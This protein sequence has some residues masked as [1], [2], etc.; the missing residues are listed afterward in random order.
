[1]ILLNVY[2]LIAFM[3]SNLIKLLYLLVFT[4]FL[5]NNSLAG[6]KEAKIAFSEG[7][8][9]KALGEFKKLADLGD[10]EAMYNLAVMYR[11]GAGNDSGEPEEEKAF[12]WYL[13]AAENGHGE[14]QFIVG[15]MYAGGTETL[16]KDFNKSNRWFK[17]SAGHHNK[18]AEFS[19]GIV[20]EEGLGVKKNIYQSYNWY[21]RAADH[22]HKVARFIMAVKYKNEGNIEKAFQF[23]TLSA[24]QGYIKSQN[25]LA[26]MYARGEGTKQNTLEAIRWYSAAAVEGDLIAIINLAA[27]YGNGIGI[28]INNVE[29]YKWFLIAGKRGD[30]NIESS[31][32]ILK[33][34]MTK[35]EIK[36]AYD[37]AELW[38]VKHFKYGQG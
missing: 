25:D 34:L 38:I 37:D 36:Q 13:K 12:N 35:K 1:M 33:P 21:K 14:S 26:G 17:K 30:K 5:I 16:K 23:Y 28:E 11:H 15:L 9:V 3:K 29:A 24:K 10:A 19:L 7:D 27:I 31:L 6:I 8:Y 20:Y 32:N 22:G 4:F 2:C 18:D